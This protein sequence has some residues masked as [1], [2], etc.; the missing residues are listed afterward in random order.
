MQLT[1]TT[2]IKVD[3]TAEEVQDALRQHIE[4]DME[5]ECLV[6]T[7]FQNYSYK[8][9]MTLRPKS[10]VAEEERRAA[11]LAEKR[12][13]ELE[14]FEKSVPDRQ[15]VADVMSKTTQHIE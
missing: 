7:D 8:T 11:E 15:V 12:K 13:R 1:K 5:M 14:E 10:E 4:R 2:E 6:V 3:M 9:M